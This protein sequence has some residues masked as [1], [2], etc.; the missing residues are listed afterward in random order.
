MVEER[1]VQSLII[2]PSLCQQKNRPR[3]VFRKM[4]IFFYVYAQIKEDALIF[5]QRLIYFREV[6]RLCL[7][8]FNY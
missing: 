3:F 2:G 5:F 8:I 1:G 6:L 7:V 4:F